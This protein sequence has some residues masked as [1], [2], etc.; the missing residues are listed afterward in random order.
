MERQDIHIEFLQENTSK[1]VIWK[2]KT[3]EYNTKKDL[4]ESLFGGMGGGWQ[5]L[6]VL[7]EVDSVLAEPPVSIAVELV[8]FCVCG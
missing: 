8:S 3:E 1:D 6:R 7:L 4:R 5:W 2:T